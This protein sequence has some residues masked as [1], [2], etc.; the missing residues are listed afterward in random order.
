MRTEIALE[1]SNHILLKAGEGFDEFFE[2][3]HPVLKEHA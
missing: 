3:I 2:A 1:G